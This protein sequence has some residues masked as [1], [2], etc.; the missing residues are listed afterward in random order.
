MQ[1]LL[2]IDS[3]NKCSISGM[4][5]SQEPF[6][7]CWLSAG[8]AKNRDTLNFRRH[9]HSFF[10]LHMITEGHLIYCFKDEYIT[11]SQGE[12]IVVSP[13]CQHPV[14]GHSEAFGK[15]TLA[16]ECAPGNVFT[17]LTAAQLHPHPVTEE[18]QRQIEAVLRYAEKKSEYSDFLLRHSLHALVYHAAEPGAVHSG[19][20]QSEEGYDDRV[21]RAKKYVEDN[22][23]VFF[24]CEEVAAYCHI[25][26]RHL[27]RLFQKHEGISLLSFIHEKKLEACKRMLT[28][29]DRTQRQIAQALGF[30][31]ADYFNKFFVRQTGMTPAQFRNSEKLR[32]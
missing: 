27:G 30:A 32:I 20:R 3:L 14:A 8:T 10:E 21:L 4:Q 5:L 18:M 25:S 1:I 28:E 22:Y 2:N 13:F 23:D 29:T 16:F 17:A 19:R 6:S 9:H 31:G 24:S 15:L 7:L 11:V 12:Y 26:V